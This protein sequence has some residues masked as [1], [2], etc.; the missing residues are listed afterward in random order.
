[1]TS[2]EKRTILEAA[3]A[4]AYTAI[5][6]T[7]GSEMKDGRF[8]D[9]LFNINTLEHLAI[10]HR[11]TE[12]DCHEPNDDVGEPN[13]FPCHPDSG[14]AKESLEAPQEQPAPEPEETEKP[15][16]EKE[17]EKPGS[18]KEEPVKLV[19]EILGGPQAE[20]VEVSF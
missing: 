3:I 10:K 12:A 14:T 20:T 8:G 18:D 1:M 17:P 15:E 19:T 7:P 6:E 5:A 11:G 2:A 13:S 16:L 4:R 9:L